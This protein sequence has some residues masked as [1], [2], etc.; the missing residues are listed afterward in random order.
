M[1]QVG[2]PSWRVYIDAEAAGVDPGVLVEDDARLAAW[3]RQETTGA[4]QISPIAA[5]IQGRLAAEM[6]TEQ[7]AAAQLGLIGV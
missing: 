6:I 1:Q 5:V 3:E 4:F 2:L 7:A